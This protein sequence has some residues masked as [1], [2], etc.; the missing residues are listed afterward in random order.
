MKIFIQIIVQE[1]SYREYYFNGPCAEPHCP[2]DYGAFL[3]RSRF[4]PHLQGF[5][6]G[7]L[8]HSSV[9]LYSSRISQAVKNDSVWTSL[10][11]SYP[12][13][14]N[15]IN[16]LT[17][18]DR[19]MNV[20]YTRGPNTTVMFYLSTKIA[21]KDGSHIAVHRTF[22]GVQKDSTTYDSSGRPWF[23]NAPQGSYYLYGPYIETF[24]RQPVVTLSSM[25]PTTD[26]TTG[27]SLQL[28]SGGVMLISELAS[29]GKIPP[30]LSSLL[31]LLIVTLLLQWI[32][33]TTPMA[34]LVSFFRSPR[35][36]YWYGKIGHTLL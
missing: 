2:S 33:W 19:D 26:S 6:N 7:S 5:I 29:I 18:Q 14:D 31:S 20:M 8:L 11:N 24:T 22:P 34:D 12:V 21:L 27:L 10:T 3:G 36:K 4:P 32:A 17:Y 25:Q 23:V 16:A 30:L 28:V 15:V 13:I 1:S 35:N 9:Y